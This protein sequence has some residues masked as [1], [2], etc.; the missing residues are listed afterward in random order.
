MS[1]HGEEPGAST[2]AP[3]W[4]R[5]TSQL[6]VGSAGCLSM[7]RRRPLP[8]EALSA[9]DAGHL[10]W[11]EPAAGDTETSSGAKASPWPDCPRVPHSL[12]DCPADDFEDH[13]PER[14]LPPTTSEVA[15]AIAEVSTTGAARLLAWYEQALTQVETR[16]E[17]LHQLAFTADG[18]SHRDE[19]HRLR[20]PGAEEPLARI[21]ADAQNVPFVGPKQRTIASAVAAWLRP[22]QETTRHG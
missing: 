10:H 4:E 19:L 8:H 20:G 16:S 1:A 6:L 22:N 2:P 5:C 18:T 14:S 17:T 9:H 13:A 11:I 21:V 3:H 15:D 7:P 12:L